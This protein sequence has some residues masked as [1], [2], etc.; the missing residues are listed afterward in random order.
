MNIV[1]RRKIKRSAD[2]KLLFFT[3]LGAFIM[4]FV[5]FTY[6]L[7]IV[8]P[9]V[10][11]PALTEEHVFNSI[12]SHDFRGRIDPRLHSIELQEELG[13]LE[14]QVKKAPVPIAAKHEKPEVKAKAP[15]PITKLP[16]QQAK[17]VDKQPEIK[18]EVGQQTV[19]EKPATPA[20]SPI[21]N[22]PPRPKPLLVKKPTVVAPPAPIFQ[23][24]VIIGSFSDPTDA[25]MTSDILT[26][27]DFKPI[28]RERSGKYI[29][30]IG[31]YADTNEAKELVKELKTRNFDARIIYE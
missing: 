10:E 19:A 15:L 6:I 7:P 17:A 18:V 27:L 5:A 24:K 28:M 25:R 16:P 23:A 12:T 9:Q 3:F 26:S 31:S 13:T 30:Q 22:I 20:P 29:L 1:Q 8:T 2:L 14:K 11:I 21:L 4:F